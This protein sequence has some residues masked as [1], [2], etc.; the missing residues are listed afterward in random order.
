MSSDRGVFLFNRYAATNCTEN[1]ISTLNKLDVG[2]AGTASQ[3]DA[4]SQNW[5]DD[6]YAKESLVIKV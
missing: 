3:L 1:D 5:F 6:S 2:F 4:I